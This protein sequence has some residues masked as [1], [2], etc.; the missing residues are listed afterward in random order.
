MGAGGAAPGARG[1]R[2]AG[3]RSPQPRLGAGAGRQP[4]AGAGRPGRGGRRVWDWGS[5]PGEGSGDLPEGCGP[6]GWAPLPHPG[7]VPSRAL[8]V[9]TRGD[10]GASGPA[11]WGPQTLRRGFPDRR[12]GW[13]GRRLGSPA[14]PGAPSPQAM[15]PVIEPPTVRSCWSCPWEVA[16]DAGP[17]GCELGSLAV[18]A[19]AT[20]NQA[21]SS[22]GYLA[23]PVSPVSFRLQEAPRGKSLLS[24]PAPIITITSRPCSPV[25]HSHPIQIH[26]HARL[27]LGGTWNHLCEGAQKSLARTPQSLPAPKAAS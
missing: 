9:W 27:D 11:P 24:P 21:P 22:C 8:E 16:A 1:E 14:G 3:G 23:W 18:R 10:G 17:K 5:G 13:V 25:P 6:P 19:C 12:C 26:T 4:G 7:P 15:R 20:G 2:G